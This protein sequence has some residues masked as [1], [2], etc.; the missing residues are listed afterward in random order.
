MAQPQI[1]AL[2]SDFGLDD[3]YVGVMKG[4]IAQISPHIPIIDLSHQIPPQHRLAARFCL[5]NAY[6]YFPPGTV[7]VAVVDPGV[8]SDRRGVAIQT[9]GG[10]LVG[11]DNGIFS[12]ILARSP[13]LAVVELS[14]SQYWRTS[15]PS[16]T[17]HGR[18][19]FAPVG[20]HLATGIPLDQIGHPLDPACLVDFSPPSPQKRDRTLHG[21]IQYIDTFG[22]LITTIPGEWVKEKTWWVEM[23]DRQIPGSTTYSSV[24]R[25]EL[26]GLIGSHGW[27]EIA[28]NCG[29]A[30]SQL[31]LNWLNEITVNC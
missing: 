8:G 26:V 15:H 3:V 20:A 28:A 10:Y 13:A 11:P 24:P 4:A 16:T 12:G 27:V 18:D 2:L 6:P 31:A 29:D 1:L 19:I 7:Y 21:H 14:N 22:N 25:G 5:L 30:R 17:F 9:E 23:G